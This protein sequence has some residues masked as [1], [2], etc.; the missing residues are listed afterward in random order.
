MAD[1][2]ADPRA[3]ASLVSSELANAGLDL[4]VEHD[5]RTLTISGVVASE[6][7]RDAAMDLASAVVG[8]QMRLDQSIDVSAAMPAVMDR[9]EFS[10]TEVAG[11][12]GATAGLEEHEAAEAGDFTDQDDLDAPSLAQPMSLTDDGEP[13]GE[14]M[15]RPAETGETYVPPTDPVGTDREVI[16][17]FQRSSMDTQEVERSSD[18]S[19]GDLALEEAVIRELREDAATTGLQVQVQVIQGVVHLYGTVAD[20]I[21]VESA[22]EVAGR[23]DGVI[24]VMEHFE[25]ESL[26]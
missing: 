21:D 19:I 1:P 26:R 17:G 4:I 12:R 15:R 20:I 22:E 8:D 9:F 7:E 11:F 25:V 6:A 24:E 14:D 5:E 18:G 16:G 3:L 13:Y 23:L 10:E 2:Q